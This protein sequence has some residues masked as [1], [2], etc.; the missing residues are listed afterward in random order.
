VTVV[1]DGKRLGTYNGP[2]DVLFIRLS[3]TPNTKESILP[4]SPLY[5]TYKLPVTIGFTEIF[6]YVMRSESASNVDGGILVGLPD[7][8]AASEIENSALVVEQRVNIETIP[9]TI[10]VPIS[11][12]SP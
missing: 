1:P 3:V 10:T 7:T 8:E 6:P 12:V 4:D 5:K 2:P 11:Q 9:V